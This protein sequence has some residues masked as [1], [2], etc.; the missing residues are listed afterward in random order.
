MKKGTEIH[1]IPLLQ[2]LEFRKVKTGLGLTTSFILVSKAEYF[3]LKHP[4]LLSFLSMFISI[5]EWHY[6]CDKTPGKR[7]NKTAE[8]V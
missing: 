1:N 4:V 6:L 2:T 5:W 3:N 8:V 7:K